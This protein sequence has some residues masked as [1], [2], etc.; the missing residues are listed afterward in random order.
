MRIMEALFFFEVVTKQENSKFSSST[1][2]NLLKIDSFYM[3]S[4]A[5]HDGAVKTVLLCAKTRV[6]KIFDEKIIFS[7]STWSKKNL[8]KLAK[9]KF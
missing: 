2:P 5:E 1:Q 7:R 8:L 4:D 9:M 3:I 6:L